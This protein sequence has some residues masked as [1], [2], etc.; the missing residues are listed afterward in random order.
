[1]GLITAQV[2][3]GAMKC[4]RVRFDLVVQMQFVFIVCPLVTTLM[5]LMVIVTR[6]RIQGDGGGSR[7]RYSCVWIVLYTTLN[8]VCCI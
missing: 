7:T 2:V 5:V 1:M 4:G 3:I 6:G 8:K